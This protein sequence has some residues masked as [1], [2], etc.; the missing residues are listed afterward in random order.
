MT[1]SKCQ[2]HLDTR[3]WILDI[4]KLDLARRLPRPDKAGLAMTRKVTAPA[5]NLTRNLAY[6]KLVT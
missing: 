4:R 1:K 5:K 6:G 2:D 3:Y